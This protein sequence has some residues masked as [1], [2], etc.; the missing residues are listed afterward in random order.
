ML[1]TGLCCS[2]LNSQNG[3]FSW[4]DFTLSSLFLIEECHSEIRAKQKCW[5]RAVPCYIQV[6]NSCKGLWLIKVLELELRWDEAFG[7]WVSILTRMGKLSYIS[8]KSKSLNRFCHL[9]DMVDILLK[10]NELNLHLW[11]LMFFQK[12]I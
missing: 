8:W 12:Y 3:K 6:I 7:E 4:S 10:L 1:K 5:R 9:C 2:V 11:D